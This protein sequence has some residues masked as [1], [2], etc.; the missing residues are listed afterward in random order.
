MNSGYF[1]TRLVH[2]ISPEGIS[3]E[4]APNRMPMTIRSLYLKLDNTLTLTDSIILLWFRKISLRFT[5]DSY[6]FADGFGGLPIASIL[7][8]ASFSPSTPDVPNSLSQFS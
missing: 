5:G 8:S 1:Y 4:L 6:G 2:L 3:L 7:F